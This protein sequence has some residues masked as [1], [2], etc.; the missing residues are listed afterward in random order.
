MN[1]TTDHFKRTIQAYLDN[2]A[3][4]DKLFAAN[5][6]KPNK[7]IE[8]CVTYILNWVQ[9]S[10]CNGF[11]DGEIYSQA[12]HYYDEDDIEVGKPLQCQ[13]VV[14]HTV[15]LTDE[16]KAEA[17]QQ[18]IRQYQ[19]E[20]LRK[21]QNR[22]KAKASQ[23]QT[24]NKLNSHYSEPMKPRNKFEKAVLAQSKKLRPITKAQMNWA[25][26]ECIDHYAH[27]LPKGR[28][29]CMDCGHSWIMDKQT[30]YYTCPECGA[31]LEVVTS[32]VR[33]VQQKQYFTVLTT[34]GEY[35]VLRMYLL[36]VEMEKGCKADP[37][38]LEIGQYWWN[39]EGRTAVVGKQRI[40]GR[41]LDLFSLPLLWLS[42]RTTSPTTTSPILR[43]TLNSR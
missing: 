40:W 5:Y 38:V 30:K 10:G 21:L 25:F 31:R 2:R 29:T 23:K 33:K 17:R 14:N 22:N 13:V 19:A 7:N 35:Q 27:R 16:E 3:A 15:E 42:G 37:Y 4:E 1:K 11:T 28:T 41:Y 34:C 36:F 24:H 39:K 6:N 20:E 18:A 26:R 32:Y 12:V 9:K 43:Y 8:D